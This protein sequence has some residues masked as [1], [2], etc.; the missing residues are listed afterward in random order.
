MTFCGFFLISLSNNHPVN[1]LIDDLSDPSDGLGKTPLDFNLA[2]CSCKNFH[3]PGFFLGR[4]ATPVPTSWLESTK[5]L[6][7]PDFISLRIA[8]TSLFIID[9]NSLSEAPFL[10]I[11]IIG[12]ALDSPLI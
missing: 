7:F 5:S 2:S 10:V 12:A 8:S 9:F 11:V 1:T 6:Y 3:T 4:F